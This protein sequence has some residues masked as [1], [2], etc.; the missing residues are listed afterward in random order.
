VLPTTAT[1]P[2]L[3]RTSL[4]GEDRRQRRE[5]KAKEGRGPGRSNSG[6]STRKV[7][8][9]TTK[10]NPVPSHLR[11]SQHKTDQEEE[12][13]SKL[14]PGEKGFSKYEDTAGE[15]RRWDE[16]KDIWVTAGE[17]VTLDLRGFEMPIWQK[18]NLSET[19]PRKKKCPGVIANLLKSPSKVEMVEN[20]HGT[21][22]RGMKKRIN[23]GKKDIAGSEGRPGAIYEN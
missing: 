12:F 6:R 22:H 4:E 19:K 11:G 17:G 15:F 3:E 8:Q 13:N 23:E 18:K 2:K 5:G 21:R 20:E 7:S 9:N 14:S 1:G 16:T 10:K